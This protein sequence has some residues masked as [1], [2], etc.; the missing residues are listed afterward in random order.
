[1]TTI[2]P[3]LGAVIGGALGYGVSRLMVACGGG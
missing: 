2:W 3:I 1:M